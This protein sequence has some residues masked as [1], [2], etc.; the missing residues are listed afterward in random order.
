MI[1]RSDKERLAALEAIVPRIE[2][3]VG[4]IET[5]QLAAH[6]QMDGHIRDTKKA[7]GNGGVTIVIGGKSFAALAT[8]A[9]VVLGGIG[10]YLKDR[11]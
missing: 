1:N 5:A 2:Q 10:A 11:W 7:N 9:T 8:G 3:A 6:E 4:R